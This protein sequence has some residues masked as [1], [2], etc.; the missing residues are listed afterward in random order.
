MSCLPELGAELLQPRLALLRSSGPAGSTR[1]KNSCTWARSSCRGVI[2]QPNWPCAFAEH[3]AKDDHQVVQPHAR[4]RRCRRR[5]C[6]SP[7]AS[8]IAGRPGEHEVARLGIDEHVLDPLQAG[9]H[10]HG[11]VRFPSK[12]LA[13]LQLL[14]QTHQRHFP[15]VRRMADRAI[16]RVGHCRAASRFEQ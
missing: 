6:G 12:C 16:A 11:F 1:V 10:T 2:R 13:E 5:R 7:V 14:L 8:P 3:V 15:Q 4:A 9:E